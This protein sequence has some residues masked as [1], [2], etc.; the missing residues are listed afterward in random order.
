MWPPSAEPEDDSSKSLTSF[1]EGEVGSE[2][3]GYLD[4]AEREG[5][6]ARGRLDYGDAEDH[7]PE[8]A[9]DYDLI[10]MGTRGRSGVSHLLRPSVAEHVV[11]RANVPVLVIHARDDARATSALFATEPATAPG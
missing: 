1:A 8:W 3:R 2:M 6:R 7:H 11:R 5:V 10:V 9:D 4:R